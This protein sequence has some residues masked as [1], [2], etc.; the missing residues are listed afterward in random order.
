MHPYV[1]W[2]TLK[3]IRDDIENMLGKT[4]PLNPYLHDLNF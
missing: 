1:K 4:S 2:I 3:K